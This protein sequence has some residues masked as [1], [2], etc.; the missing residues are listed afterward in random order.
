[1]G[2]RFI[3]FRSSIA[4]LLSFDTFSHGVANRAASGERERG[5]EGEKDLRQRKAEKGRSDCGVKK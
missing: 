2:I 5:D 4:V 3:S 1:L